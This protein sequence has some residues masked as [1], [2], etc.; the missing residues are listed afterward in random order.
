MFC[1]ECKNL[2]SHKFF[3]G[4]LTVSSSPLTSHAKND[5]S[6]ILECIFLSFTETKMYIILHRPVGGLRFWQISLNQKGQLWTDVWRVFVLLTVLRNWQ[7]SGWFGGSSAGL[8]QF[9]ELSSQ[10][11]LSNEKLFTFWKIIL[12]ICEIDLWEKI[13]QGKSDKK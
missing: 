12:K 10:N 6:V 1:F 11:Q 13:L 3:S 2:A 9:K 5:I 7:S 4:F 8:T